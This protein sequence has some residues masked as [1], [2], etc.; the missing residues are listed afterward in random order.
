MKIKTGIGFDAHSFSE[1]RDLIIGGVKIPYDKGLLGHSD[2]DVLAHAIADSIA[3]VALHK[4]IGA[5]F[6]DTDSA[7][8][9]ADSIKLLAQVAKLAKDAHWEI[10]SI[11]AVIIAQAPKMLPYIS[12]M[13]ANIANAVGIPLD[14]IS[15]KATTTEHLGFTGRKE[16]IA[17]MAVV[18]IIK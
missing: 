6:P 7:Y 10:S 14:D 4:D 8:K 1:G 15:L 9:N 17:A 11:D 3:G 12:T 16:G 5:L 13:C 2:A 18:T